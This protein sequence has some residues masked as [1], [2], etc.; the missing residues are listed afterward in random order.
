MSDMMSI[1]QLLGA[2]LPDGWREATPVTYSADWL[3]PLQDFV[4]GGGDHWDYQEDLVLS[5]NGLSR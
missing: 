4:A 2:S 5:I 3:S 1:D